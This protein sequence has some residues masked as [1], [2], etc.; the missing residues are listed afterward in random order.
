MQISQFSTLYFYSFTIQSFQI[1][2][3]KFI[4]HQLKKSQT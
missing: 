3:L 2:P 1:Y 4:N